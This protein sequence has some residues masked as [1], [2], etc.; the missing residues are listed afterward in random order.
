[1]LKVSL[2]EFC[3]HVDDDHFGCTDLYHYDDF[4][5]PDELV[6]KL[7]AWADAF[8]EAREHPESL[9]IERHNRVGLEIAREINA[10]SILTGQQI[11]F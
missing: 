6:A 8:W 9:D 10:Q 7:D 4:C 5:L 1:M 3:F 11:R 2:D